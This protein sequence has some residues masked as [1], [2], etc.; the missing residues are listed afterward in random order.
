MNNIELRPATADDFDFLYRLHRAALKEYIAQTW[1][2]DEG[3]Q[4]RYFEQH[5]DPAASQVIQFK[6]RDAGVVSVVECEGEIF[7]AN[8]AVTPD[9]QG[10]G[11]GTSVIQQVLDEA[12][13]SGKPVVLR[14]L[15]VNPAR[16]LY[17]RLGFSATGENETHYFMKATVR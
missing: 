9:L 7:L 15:K 10:Q 8:I 16:R 12:K 1:G 13:R 6:K 14:V 2:W 3:W 4:Q 17:E 5:F 11:I